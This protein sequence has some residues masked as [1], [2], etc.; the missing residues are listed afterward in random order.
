[1]IVTHSIVRTSLDAGADA[2]AKRRE[3]ARFSISS[4]PARPCGAATSLAALIAASLALSCTG[5]IAGPANGSSGNVDGNSPSGGNGGAA[6][7]GPSGNDIPSEE[8]FACVDG[9]TSAA[10]PRRLWRLTG[11]QFQNTVRSVLGD[12]PEGLANPFQ[13]Q[14]SSDR[15]SN[16][17]ATYAVEHEALKLL[18]DAA[19]T[20]SAAVVPK[21]KNAHGCLSDAV[22]KAC[23]EGV[24]KDF[25]RRAFRRS[26]TEEE[27]QRYT[28]LVT[29]SSA[30]GPDNSLRVALE[31][32]LA[33]PNFAYRAELGQPSA[34]GRFQLSAEELAS[35]L[36]YSVADAPPDE[37]LL[38]AASAGKLATAEGLSAEA[39]RLFGDLGKNAPSV[40]FI[41]EYFKYERA[42]GVFKGD[43]FPYYAPDQLVDETNRLV[44]HLLSGPREGFLQQLLTTREA[45]VS[46]RTAEAYG[47]T[48]VDSDDPV[49]V[50]LPSGE[51]AGLLTQPSFLAS[52]SSAEENQPVQ[53]G[54]FILESLLCENVPELPMDV[55]P[56]L[57]D[58]GPDTTLRQRLGAHVS[59][60]RCAACHQHLD[61]LGLSF[62]M[63]D[64]T[65]RH[66]T[67]ENGQPVDATGALAGTGAQDG[68]FENAVEMSERLAGSEV[69]ERCYLRHAFRYWMG[70][71]ETKEDACSLSGAAEAL[72]QAKGDTRQMFVG[73]L[74]S[75]SFRYRK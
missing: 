61:P 60:E 33:S 64:H 11:P 9:D 20:I 28:E 29:A 45:Y 73:I 44:T 6:G 59:T 10:G 56:K 49:L 24:L 35:A 55:V 48:G 75:D 36:S 63:F 38:A 23:I 39:E 54:R 65:G 67:T 34:D 5:E 4:G 52:Y 15:F 41:A 70:R 26:L 42:K 37:E 21:L 68:P 1:L 27:V 22:D 2:A 58:L 8:L 14:A 7:S 69:V 74:S 72:T 66:R 25:G 32:V 30:L 43:E 18:M 53:R 71:N 3:Q 17:A 47:V 50:T 57:P 31:T 19:E 46:K 12:F 40:R 16:Y 13:A 51:R 62:E